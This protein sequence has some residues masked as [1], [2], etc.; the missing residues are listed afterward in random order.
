VPSEQ[1]ATKRLK[2]GRTGMRAVIV[3]DWS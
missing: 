1:H 3:T 2:G